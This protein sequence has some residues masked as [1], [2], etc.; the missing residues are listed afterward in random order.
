MRRRKIN[1]SSQRIHSFKD[2][3]SKTSK[4]PCKSSSFSPEELKTFRMKDRDKF[5]VRVYTPQQIQEISSVKLSSSY[6]ANIKR[7]LKLRKIR[8]FLLGITESDLLEIVQQNK[9]NH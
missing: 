4:W 8:N 9:N 3:D 5:V 7:D 6:I 2:I 1:S